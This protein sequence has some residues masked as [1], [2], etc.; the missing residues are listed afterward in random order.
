MIMV[1][2]DPA[3][4]KRIADAVCLVADGAVSGPVDTADIFANPPQALRD[5]LGQMG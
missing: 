1:T 5:Y 4:A 3:D 2:H